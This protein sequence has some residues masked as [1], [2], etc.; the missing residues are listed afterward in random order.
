[1]RERIHNA[2]DEV[3]L[4]QTVKQRVLEEVLMGQV[5]DSRGLHDRIQESQSSK[6]DRIR[7]QFQN[8]LE[9]FWQGK[10]GGVVVV[11][12]SL[13]VLFCVSIGL[14]MSSGR[15][16]SGEPTHGQPLSGEADITNADQ[17]GNITESTGEDSIELSHKNQAFPVS[18]PILTSPF[19]DCYGRMHNGID[20]TVKDSATASEDEKSVR[21]VMEGRVTFADYVSEE[22]NE[23]G[24]STGY[25]YT[26]MITDDTGMV[27][28]YSHLEKMNVNVGDEVHTGDVIGVMGKTGYATGICL[29]FSVMVNGEFVDP[30]SYFGWDSIQ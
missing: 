8:R 6:K 2:F 18:C 10:L 24:L 7:V 11:M 15:A 27:T 4:N 30:L 3:E 5:A 29:H 25:G 22:N 20:L 21:S 23:E 9:E 16:H 1:M 13:V 17:Q 26:I 12:A 19:G 14:V 28:Q